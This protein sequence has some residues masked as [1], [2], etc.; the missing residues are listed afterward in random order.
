MWLA[1]AL[2]APTAMRSS[3]QRPL[4]LAVLGAAVA[5]TLNLPRVNGL[6]YLV[7]GPT[8]VT[9]LA[10]NL[11]GVLTSAA[12]LDFVFLAARG[13]HTYP[14]YAVAGL[15]MALLIWLDTTARAHLVHAIPPTGEPSPSTPYWA[16]LIT[17]NLS[18][19]VMCATACWQYSRTSDPALRAGL[20]LFG[21]GAV[22]AG[23]YWLLDATYFGVRCSWIPSVTPLLMGCYAAARASALCVPVWAAAAL[24]LRRLKLLWQLWPLWRDLVD[25]VPDVCL[26]QRRRRA[27]H[28]LRWPV[29]LDLR[30]YRT[31]IEIRDA[32]LVLRAYAP[33]TALDDIRSHFEHEGLPPAEANSQALACWL[34]MARNSKAGGAPPR[35]DTLT[36][37][38]LGGSDLQH[39]IDFLR[40]VSKAN[41]SPEVRTLASRLG[42]RSTTN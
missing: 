27:H 12:V 4:W 10:R 37:P 29:P 36:I 33:Q 1:V 11:V 38:V 9:A 21:L 20:R 19:N 8:H 35:H 26:E 40:K 15:V 31:V 25:A 34:Y 5:V 30:L 16:V 13:R 18:T 14:L 41:S 28:F 23:A 24:T 3:E 17:V 2:R 6:V 7:T 32:I 22:F 39:E 42:H